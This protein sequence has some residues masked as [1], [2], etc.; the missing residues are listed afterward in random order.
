MKLEE[1]DQS[2]GRKMLM[3]DIAR[4]AGIAKRKYLVQKISN[5][6]CRMYRKDQLP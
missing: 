3:T 4:I 2:R 5:F 1:K 6:A